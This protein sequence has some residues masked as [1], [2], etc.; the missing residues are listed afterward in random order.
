ML[1]LMI[2]LITDHALIKCILNLFV[3]SIEEKTDGNTL[4][5]FKFTVDLRFHWHAIKN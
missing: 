4:R 3:L 5:G 2:Y 1:S